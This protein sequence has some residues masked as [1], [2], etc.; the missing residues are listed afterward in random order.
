MKTKLILFLLMAWQLS[1]SQ[2]KST[3]YYFIRHAEKVDNSKDPNLSELGMQRAQKWKA[4]FESIDF[5]QI[6]STNY[7]RTQQT[8]TPIATADKI[9]IQLYDPQKIDLKA[10]KKITLGRKVLIVGHSNT[11]PDFV[12]KIINQQVFN[13]IEDTTFGNLYIVTIIGD[14]ISYQLLKLP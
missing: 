10:F 14:T 5:D 3:T 8:A 4:I 1:F 2:Q 11:T 12:N 9:E 13:D 6:Y 7:K